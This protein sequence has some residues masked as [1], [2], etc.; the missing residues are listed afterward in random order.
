MKVNLGCGPNQLPD[1]VNVDLHHPNA[2]VH[3]D[4]RE[5]A[6]TD[7]E[8]VLMSHLLEHLPHRDCL[9]ALKRIHGW[10]KP[11]GRAEVEVPDMERIFANGTRDPLW[12]QYTYGCQDNDGEYHKS[13]FTPESLRETMAAAGFRDVTVE[14]FLSDN[15]VR[16]RMPCVKAVGFA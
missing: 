16:D 1:W 6:F 5:V 14:A 11:G 12:L 9:P 10:M 3:G 7:V 8:Q 4:V 2:N 13:G 15:P